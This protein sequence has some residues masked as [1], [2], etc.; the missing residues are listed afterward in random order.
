MRTYETKDTML[1]VCGK[2]LFRERETQYFSL[3]YVVIYANLFAHA[4]AL[5]ERSFTSHLIT[6]YPQSPHKYIRFKERNYQNHRV[7]SQTLA[8]YNVCIY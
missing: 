4:R 1:E 2:S 6:H 7:F 5:Q 3:I 8:K